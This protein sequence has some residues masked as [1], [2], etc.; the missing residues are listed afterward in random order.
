MLLCMPPRPL[1]LSSRPAS[2][3]SFP[4]ISLL[5]LL[6]PQLLFIDYQCDLVSE[7]PARK[8]PR[9]QVGANDNHR[10][11]NSTHS[12]S[13]SNSQACP[14]SAHVRRRS[15]PTT[16][17]KS[18]STAPRCAK[19]APAETA[20]RSVRSTRAHAATRMCAV[21]T[22]CG[23]AHDVRRAPSNVAPWRESH[24]ADAAGCSDRLAPAARVVARRRASRPRCRMERLAVWVTQ[25]LARIETQLRLRDGWMAEVEAVR[26][27]E[28]LDQVR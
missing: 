10:V 11:R 14:L 13:P 4:H 5:P 19:A 8:P 26:S 16:T 25:L 3:L 12:L 28:L 15:A 2:L 22:G 23:I 24:G 7:D 21:R 6:S 17:S 20:P 1:L 9:T 27:N 18:P